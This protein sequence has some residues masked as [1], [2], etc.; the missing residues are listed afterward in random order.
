MTARDD[1]LTEAI[2]AFNRRM[3]EGHPANPTGQKWEDYD[4]DTQNLFKDRTIGALAAA[5]DVIL[6]RLE[7]AA[8]VERDA[9][10]AA[11]DAVPK[12]ERGWAEHSMLR[13]L[14]IEANH[15]HWWLKRKRDN[16]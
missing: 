2:E 5:Y 6:A 9:R 3:I 7:H 11:F 12:H 15:A 14:G 1:I 13:D 4:R 16:G 10:F 8:A